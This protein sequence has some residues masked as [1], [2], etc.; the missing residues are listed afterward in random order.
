MERSDL[1]VT[2][3]SNGYPVIK[4]LLKIIVDEFRDEL[5]NATTN[6]EV[7]RIHALS[8]S[9]GIVRNA[10]LKRVEL[11]LTTQRESR[12]PEAPQE[13]APGIDMD[14]IE[15][16]TENLPNLLGDVTYIEESAEEAQPNE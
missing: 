9:A 5:D 7:V 8:K 4:K 10:F 11:E 16:I 6:A 15:R 14:D 3:S 1:A 13:S 12:P 2:A